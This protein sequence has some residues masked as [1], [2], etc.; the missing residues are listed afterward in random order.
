M[1]WARASATAARVE[2][3]SCTT[4]AREVLGVLEDDEAQVRPVDALRPHR[5]ADRLGR[6]EP[7][8]GRDHPG[9]HPGEGGHAGDLV[10]DDVGALFGQDLVARTW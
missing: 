4:A 8:L 10:V 1:P 9:H 2:A 3:T 5:A 6:H 7:V